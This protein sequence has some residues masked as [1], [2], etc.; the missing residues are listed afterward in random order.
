MT[1][2]VEQGE[3]ENINSLITADESM[4]NHI[5]VQLNTSGCPWFYRLFGIWP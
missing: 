5:P 2:E 3:Y 4:Y 1:L